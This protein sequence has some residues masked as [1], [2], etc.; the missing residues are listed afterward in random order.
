[1][2]VWVVWDGRGRSTKET[3][4]TT[5]ARDRRGTTNKGDGERC[6]SGS[7]SWIKT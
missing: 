1:M 7:Q 5:L 3:E 6:V 2:S 4:S